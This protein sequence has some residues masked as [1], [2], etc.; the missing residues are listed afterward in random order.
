VKSKHDPTRARRLI[1]ALVITTIA[2]APVAAQ[3]TY[4]IQPTAKTI[5]G[6]PVAKL[7]KKW[8]LASLV[9]EENLPADAR[10]DLGRVANP[11]ARFVVEGDFNHDARHDKAVV[12]VYRTQKGDEGQFLLIVTQAAS[13]SW[14]VAYLGKHPGFPGPGLL[15]DTPEGLTWALC[16]ACDVFAD[17]SVEHGRY[18]LE[19]AET[20]VP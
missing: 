8:A 18:R 5:L 4:R 19:W 14:G 2:A 10:E 17:V 12:G 6:I 9:T 1:Q 7:D 11:T 15:Y 3:E 16:T 13:G 20:D